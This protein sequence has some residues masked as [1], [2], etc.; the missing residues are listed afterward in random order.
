MQSV[1]LLIKNVSLNKQEKTIVH[2]AVNA[3][4]IVDIWSEPRESKYQG[5][6]EVDGNGQLLTAGLI[7]CHTHLVYGGHRSHEFEWRLNGETYQ[8]IAQKGGGIRS[9]V[10]ATRQ[11][12]FDEL[13]EASAKRLTS[14]IEQGVLAFE[15]KSGY[16]LDLETEMKML[17]VARRLAESF[18]LP[19][20]TTFLGAHT[21]PKEYQGN[22][23]DYIDYIC[24]TVLPAVQEEGLADAVDVFCENIAFNVA[25]ATK[26]FEAAQA[27]NLPIK[28]HAEQISN[29]G[30]SQLAA[31][32]GARS[33]EHL[34]FIDEQGVRALADNQVVAVLLPGA[35]YFLRETQKPPIDL[36]RKY[37][38][39][40]AIATDCNPGSSP[41]TSL[42]LMMNMACTFFGLTVAEVWQA[43]TTH[44]ALALGMTEP[45]LQVGSEA[46][47]VL[48]PFTDP[49]DLVYT[50]GQFERPKVFIKGQQFARHQ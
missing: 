17:R 14:M 5:L 8:S 37:N 10:L 33:C 15:V 1:D 47:F 46:T 44:A 12:T 36:F 26:I 25:Q 42:P 28:C 39:P 22:A 24:E 49:V 4:K 34:E 29:M 32:Y 38:V 3:G 43:V 16:G 21:I 19:I 50:V 41:T 9:T 2:V 30:G 27:F 6:T 18:Q 11:A 45:N 48:W 7:D 20:S 31:Q 23:D 13:Y 35:F 40:M